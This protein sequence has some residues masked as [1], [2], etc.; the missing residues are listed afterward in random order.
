[1]SDNV[2]E[3][4]EMVSESVRYVGI[5]S[6]PVQFANQFAVQPDQDGIVL[7]IGQATSSIA[8]GGEETSQQQ[9][10]A[11]AHVPVR[12]LARIFLPPARVR[13]LAK[14]LGQFVQGPE[15][16]VDET[17]YLLR[18]PANAERLLAAYRQA[19]NR[20]GEPQTVE[21]LRRKL[22]LAAER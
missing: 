1:M 6:M 7:T 9:V 3:Q 17:A 12:T 16:G 5:E 19:K 14:L 11:L 18:S 13:E 20:E 21:S 10:Q 2:D 8:V 22:G 15:A 4:A